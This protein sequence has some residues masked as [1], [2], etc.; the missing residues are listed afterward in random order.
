MSR[1]NT[2]TPQ[3][4]SISKQ[5]VI[6][7]DTKKKENIGNFKNGLQEYHSNKDPR[8]VLDHDFPIKELGKIS[9]YGVYNLNNNTVFVN[10]GTSHDTSEFALESISHR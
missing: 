9:P 3:R 8:N 5:V 4:R 6:F 10:V 2:S 1:L 7:V